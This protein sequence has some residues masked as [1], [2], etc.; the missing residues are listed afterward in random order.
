MYKEIPYL[1]SVATLPNYKLNVEFEDGVKGE[2]DLA[3]LV[4][5]GVFSFWNNENNFK[6]YVVNDMKKIEWGNDID[7]DPDAFYLK[8][9]NK[10]FFEYARD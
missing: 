9:I 7:M 6:N 8:L 4:G 2:I 1:K 3:Y 5:K 10:T